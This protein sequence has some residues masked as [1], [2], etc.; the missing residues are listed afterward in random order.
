MQPIGSA[1]WGRRT[2]RQSIPAPVLGIGGLLFVALAAL[3]ASHAAFPLLL[4]F[5][6]VLLFLAP[7]TRGHRALYRRSPG[8]GMPVGGSREAEPGGIGKEKELLRAL[9]RHGEITAARAAL[10]TSLS[11][12]E[13]EEMLSGLA[14]N[15]HLRVG[16]KDGALA[17]AL[18]E[19]SQLPPGIHRG[20][21]VSLHGRGETDRGERSSR[22]R[23]PMPVPHTSSEERLP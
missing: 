16:A 9:E 20:P 10:E 4:L 22:T 18:W 19:E 14:S 13:A 1:G 21:D 12:A 8:V 17:Y 23:R 6:A 3:A 7:R 2:I 11:V 15:G 5:P